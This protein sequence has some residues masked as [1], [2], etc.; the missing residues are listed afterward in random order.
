MAIEDF[1]NRTR[2]TNCDS[3]ITRCPSQIN[4]KRNFCSEDCF[5]EYRSQ[6]SNSTNLYVGDWY[7]KRKQA[8]ERDSFQCVVCGM[9]RE[10]HRDHF[11]RG[12]DVHHKTPVRD[13]DDPSDAHQLENLETLCRKHHAQ[14]E[15]GWG[16]AGFSYD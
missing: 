10:E 5:H 2:C 4:E 15:D 14:R 13:F 7:S 9:G 6:N 1:H 3:I 12:L 16:M 11:G 8:L